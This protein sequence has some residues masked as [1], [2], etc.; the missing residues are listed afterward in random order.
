MTQYFL[1]FLNSNFFLALTTAIVGAVAIFL[2]IKQ[3][4][5]K[6]RDAANIILM[7]IRKAEQI[8]NNY[9]KHG[10]VIGVTMNKILNQNSWNRYNY[11]FINYLDR[12]ELDLINNFYAT[13]SK[14]DNTIEQLDT[15]HQLR[16]KSN[17]VH[18]TLSLIAKDAISKADFQDKKSKYLGNI[19][20][21]GFSFNANALIDSVTK[22]LSSLGFV[23]TTTVGAKLKKI[24]KLKN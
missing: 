11:L 19:L 24:A 6:K 13:C 3:K 14:L 4:K 5:D 23:T 12:D 21:D 15:S 7:E 2:Y 17:A 9:K 1:Q 18:S 10:V 16:E 22:E 8:I 20:E